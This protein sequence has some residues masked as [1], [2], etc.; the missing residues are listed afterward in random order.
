MYSFH[1][2][3]WKV[4]SIPD[5]SLSPLSGKEGV[6]DNVKTTDDKRHTTTHNSRSLDQQPLDP[7]WLWGF[8]DLDVIYYPLENH[9]YFDL[10]RSTLHKLHGQTEYWVRSTCC[11]SGGETTRKRK[12]CKQFTKKPSMRKI[13]LIDSC[14]ILHIYCIF[15]LSRTDV[16]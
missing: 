16:V 7:A 13:A 8:G 4:Q 10:C 2:I 14:I 11:K 5:R 9:F 1:F 12:L 6:G 15:Q 3:Y